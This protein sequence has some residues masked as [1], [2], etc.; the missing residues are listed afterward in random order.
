[1]RSLWIS[2]SLLFCAGLAMPQGIGTLTG[3]VSDPA[4]AVV[5]GAPVQAKNSATGVVYTAAASATGNYTIANLP[6]GTYEVSVAAPGFKKEVRPGVE[7]AAATTFRVDFTLQVGQAAESVTITAEAP[8]L[9]TESGELSH[10]VT[11]ETLNE[12]PILSIGSDGAG[13]RNPLASLELLPGAQFSSDYQLVINGMPSSSQSIHI[14]GQDATNGFWKEINS[15]IQPNVDAIQEVVVETSNFAAEFGQAGGGYIN[16]TM[17]SGTNQYH[18]GAFDYLRNEALNAG[19]PFTDAG[20]TN[21]AKDGQLVRN[22]LRENDYGGTFGGPV[23][24]GKL[25]N[26]TNK[27]FFFFSFEGYDNNVQ[28]ANG[29]STVPTAAYLQGNLSSSLGPALTINGA[30]QKDP[31]GQTLVA[32]QVFD[33]L[34]QQVVDGETVRTAFPNDTIP[35]TR[36]DPAAVKILSLI[37]GATNSNALINN[38]YVPNYSNYTHTEVPAL[39]IDHNISS[40]IKLSFFYTAN[41][42]YSPGNNGYTEVWTSAEPTNSLSQTTRLNYDQTIT[43]TLLMHIGVGLLQT[44][45]YLVPTNT[46]NQSQLFGNNGYYIPY[47]PAIGGTSST[48]FGGLGI[49]GGELGASAVFALWEKDTHP[50]VGQSFTWVKGNHTFKF[51]GDMIF[52]GLPFSGAWRANGVYTFASQETADPFSTGNTYGNGATGFGYGSFLLGLYNS[53]QVAGND[54]ARLGNHSVDLYAQDSW[55]VRRNLTIDYGLRW[56]FATLLAE[57]HG[58]MQDADFN[59]VNPTIGRTGTVIYGGDC[60]TLSACPL[61]HN[62]PFAFGPRLGIAYQIDSNTVLRLGG[63]ISYGTSS[64]NAY[65][66]YSVPDY[67]TLSDQPEA[68]IPAGGAFYLGN[69]FAPGNTFGIAPLKW[70]NFTPQYPFETAPGY[71]PPESPF[72]SIDRNA[73]R[74]PRQLQW[75]LGVQ[76]QI[77]HGL[78]VDIAYVGNRGVWWTAPLLD[79]INYNS[80][81]P[82]VVAAAGITT[83]TL[84]LLDLPITSPLVQ[85]AFPNLKIETLPSGLQVVPSVYS[86]FPASQTL[87]QALRSYPQWDGVPPFLG[88]PLGDTWYDSMQLKVTRRFW[89]NLSA[90]YAFTWQKG[91][92]LGAGADTSYLTPD[93]PRINDVF[94]YDQ[95]KQLNGL[96]YPLVSVI[97]VTYQTP[98]L[99]GDSSGVKA[100]SW[101]TKDWTIAGLFRYQSGALIPTAASNNNYLFELQRGFTNNPALW[102]GGATFQNLTGQPLFLVNPNCGCFDPTKQ[103]VLNPA[104]FTDALPGTF[105]TAPAYLNNYRWQ[106]QPAES[107][108][109]GR[110]FPLSKENKVSLQ[111]RMEFIT[112]LFNRLF[113]SAPSSTNPESATLYTNQFMNGQPGAL[114]LGYGF[115]N[116]VNGAGT[117]PRQ[118]QIVA[119]LTF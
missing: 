1:M 23:R 87:G 96:V 67:Y 49:Q 16:Y 82:A 15:Q 40:T 109:L 27:T 10:N 4:G 55:K 12:L 14:E 11:T 64:N 29:L 99:H 98:K 3:T 68:G 61:N 69:P 19:T 90:N 18:G 44:T 33:P 79:S 66:N 86:T 32:N 50:T 88:P 38:F 85:Q 115:V 7:V 22:R 95:N 30:T 53:V 65:L 73:G 47:F 35:I 94:N 84:S 83:N 113:Y 52:E 21:S 118:G 9:K 26:G 72:I 46:Y 117:Q 78:V 97:S 100:A 92:D 36:W 20:L 93:A 114:S 112:N 6:A 42:E 70:P 34:T 116:T 62:Y 74:L 13:V 102:G 8:L 54:V 24:L 91:L 43:P 108:S 77:G 89:H 75:S 56:D 41:R 25:Y 17:K 2:C 71:A 106:R 119:R 51:G 80:L 39:K 31:L 45:Q 107:A 37:P 105:G 48:T 63:G 57:E 104:A 81:T 60:S 5:A 103:L 28:V 76:R 110:I 101:I 59:L 111:I 58:R